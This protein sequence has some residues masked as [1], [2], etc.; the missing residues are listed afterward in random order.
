MQRDFLIF[1]SKT[2]HFHRIRSVVEYSAHTTYT[3]TAAINM[4]FDSLAMVARRRS[5]WW[6]WHFES[7]RSVCSS[8]GTFI[9]CPFGCQH[10]QNMLYCQSYW[11]L[12]KFLDP[13]SIFHN[14]SSTCSAM[15]CTN[16][17]E[18]ARASLAPTICGTLHGSL[19]WW[20]QFIKLTFQ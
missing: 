17:L 9:M 13:V 16:E 5:R 10:K 18:T 6:W 1:R 2:N 15:V 12:L 7:I 14:N 11:K 19:S 4:L 3:F 20:C 8:N